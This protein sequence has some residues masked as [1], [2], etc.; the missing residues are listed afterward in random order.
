LNP[1]PIF[2]LKLRKHTGIVLLFQ[3]QTYTITGTLEQCQVAYRDAQIHNLAAGWWSLASVLFWNWFALIANARAMSEV[4]TAAR[5]GR[6]TYVDLTPR[7]AG[8]PPPG[9]YPDPSGAPGQRYWDG[10]TWTQWSNPPS[11]QRY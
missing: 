7:P 4:R 9:W 11:Q 6:G 5:E 1:T 3:Q 2:Y 10:R 8:P